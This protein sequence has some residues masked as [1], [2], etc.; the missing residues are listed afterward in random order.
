MFF[1]RSATSHR[2][3]TAFRR[4]DSCEHR[5]YQPRLEVLEQRCMLAG[6]IASGIYIE[7]FS[8]ATDPTKPA[9]DSSGAFQ[10]AFEFSGKTH[11][12]TD[13]SDTSGINYQIF[14]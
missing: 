7:D 6:A 9:F 2:T 11:I 8:S 3:R 13:V 10:H 1:L 4:L 12:V 5:F 14:N